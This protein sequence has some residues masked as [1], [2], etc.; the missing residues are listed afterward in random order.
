M[1]KYRVFK[2]QI[3]LPS[4]LYGRQTCFHNIS[5][6]ASISR[7]YAI[8]QQKFFSVLHNTFQKTF[9]GWTSLIFRSRGLRPSIRRRNCSSVISAASCVV[10]G[11][12]REPSSNLLYNSR[13][14]FPIQRRPFI[15]SERLPQNRKRVPFSN[16]FRLY[17]EPMT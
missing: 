2:V 17:C 11:H 14:P 1:S 12:V 13:N 10:L 3:L 4:H 15:R 5:K 9:A 6:S 8:K 7:F 16:G